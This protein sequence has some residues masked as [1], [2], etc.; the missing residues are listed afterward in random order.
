MFFLDWGT[1]SCTWPKCSP[2]VLIKEFITH[3]KYVKNGV[4][5]AG[6]DRKFE[7]F[8][9]INSSHIWRAALWV[10]SPVGRVSDG[11]SGPV[12]LDACFPA[13]LEPEQEEVQDTEH[14]II[15]SEDS[16]AKEIRTRCHQQEATRIQIETWRP[17]PESASH[18][19]STWISYI[20][21]LA[22]QTGRLTENTLLSSALAWRS[23]CSWE[24]EAPSV[25]TLL[26]RTCP[27]SNTGPLLLSIGTNVCSTCH[28][29]Y[30]KQRNQK[31]HWK[32]WELSPCQCTH[33]CTL[34]QTCS[35]L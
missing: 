28:S 34:W 13:A 2:K 5:S 29:Q 16:R 23:V 22:A 18:S 8:T 9:V 7:T 12:L 26:S 30:I 15:V 1:F 21:K 10:F 17:R 4:F 32:L 35:L 25:Q 24:R 33:T 11:R 3:P 19:Y 27:V 14:I 6:G 20:F 31:L